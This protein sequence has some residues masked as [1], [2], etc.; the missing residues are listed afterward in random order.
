MTT[1][2][3]HYEATVRRLSEKSVTKHFDAYAD[4]AWDDPALRVD[5]SD[6][7]W[8]LD[9]D[10]PLGRT[11]WYRAQRPETRARLGLHSIVTQ[12]KIGIEFESVLSRG[13]LEFASTLPNGAPEFRYVYHEMIEEGQHS[14]MFQELINRSGLDAPGM[15]RLEALVAQRVPGLARRFPELFFLF[16]LGGEAPIDHVQR[17]ELKKRDALHPLLRRVMQIHVTEEARHLCFA[18]QYLLENVPKLSSFRRFQLKVRTP[19]IFY[20]MA[21]QMLEPPRALIREYS[22]P[23]EVVRKAYADNPRHRQRTLESLASVRTLC[24]ELGLIEPKLWNAL[25]LLPKDEDNRVAAGRSLEPRKA[26]PR[27]STP[28]PGIVA[29]CPRQWTQPL[30]R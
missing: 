13:L 23:K 12:M 2:A 5:P 16:V 15:G 28:V 3:T 1:Q 27:A 30:C 17:R 14:L 4:I 29:P 24:D 26:R 11:D 18:K 7:R 19:V 8:E 20:G 10:S 9:T 6:P 22:I 25:G 21:R